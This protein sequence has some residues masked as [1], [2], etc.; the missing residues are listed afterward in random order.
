MRLMVQES[1]RGRGAGEFNRSPLLIERNIFEVARLTDRL[2]KNGFR[3]WEDVFNTPEKRLWISASGIGR[4]YIQE[5]AEFKMIAERSVEEKANTIKIIQK[6]GRYY[7]RVF[8]V[9]DKPVSFIAPNANFL[10]ENLLLGQPVRVG[11]ASQVNTETI[12]REDIQEDMAFLNKYF[13]TGIKLEL[14]GRDLM[15][16]SAIIP[17]ELKIEGPKQWRVTR[18]PSA[19]TQGRFAI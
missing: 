18:K 10:I 4:T 5:I 16:I 2:R 15:T 13:G 19:P 1:E 8:L 11:S 17:E 6:L 3:H 9:D 12:T 14:Q 7:K